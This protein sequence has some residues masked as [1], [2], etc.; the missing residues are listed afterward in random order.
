MN[1]LHRL[2]QV[3]QAPK[4]AEDASTF[5]SATKTKSAMNADRKA[6]ILNRLIYNLENGDN[7]DKRYAV[8]E[9]EEFKSPLAIPALILSLADLDEEIRRKSRALL[10]A[11]NTAWHSTLEAKSVIP[12]VIDKLDGL[13]E[14]VAKRAFQVLVELKEVG[15][16]TIVAYLNDPSKKDV[17][18]IDL[19]RLLSKFDPGTEKV[20]IQLLRCT[21][22][23]NDAI[24]ITSLTALQH[25]KGL[26]SED[27]LQLSDLLHQPVAEIQ[28]KTLQIISDHIDQAQP[29]AQ[30]IGELLF[31]LKPEIRQ[32]AHQLLEKI[33]PQI[34][35][36]LL[37]FLNRVPEIRALGLKII[38]DK[39]GITVREGDRSLLL[40]R[41]PN[42]LANAEWYTKD[43]VAEI[44][45]IEDGLLRT[46]NLM[47]TFL[48]SDLPVI[49]ALINLQSDIN[50]DIRKASFETLV[51]LDPNAEYAY[52][53][54]LE[55]YFNVK[56]EGPVFHWLNTSDPA[57]FA[58]SENANL[59]LTIITE[60]LAQ[61][62]AHRDKLIKT[63]S[64]ISNS[65]IQELIDQ[66]S[67]DDAVNSEIVDLLKAAH[68]RQPN[69][70]KFGQS[71][72]KNQLPE[73][74]RRQIGFRIPGQKD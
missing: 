57:F 23:N 49:N 62:K 54:L 70:G 53:L 68:Q 67:S 11:T 17:V 47:K 9:L 65:Q 38:Y 19:I 7:K 34:W 25:Q 12:R 43:V 30:K 59:L 48:I 58:H 61:G 36:T 50:P 1:F 69:V 72:Q 22:S 52:K 64:F 35:L 8:G 28:S 24:I 27:L 56:D 40:T 5:P 44:W 32:Q 42:A 46:I 74:G 55:Q 33:G 13:N 14:Q 39:Y 29:L 4:K 41:T 2:K 60:S 63:L 71:D 21:Q 18:K 31:H 37:N 20:K 16:D 66:W 73:G 3:F 15:L 26:N 10:D 45:K 6:R 51:A